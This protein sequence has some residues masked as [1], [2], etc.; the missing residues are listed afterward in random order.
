MK[1]ETPEDLKEFLK[2]F[3]KGCKVEVYLFGS[4]AKGTHS[5][6]SD[7]DLAFFSECDLEEKLTLLEEILENS[8][9]P[10]KVYL[11]DLRKSP[12]MWEVVKKE[13]KRW[14]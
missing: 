14:L 7:F 12:Y 1:I 10:Y 4:R 9:F 13:G 3:F 6:F 2:E 8:N 11:I 5:E